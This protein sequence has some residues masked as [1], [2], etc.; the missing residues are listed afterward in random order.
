MKCLL[1]RPLSH[2]GK[3]MFTF[4]KHKIL[5]SVTK[6][7]FNTNRNRRNDSNDEKVEEFY[8]NLEILKLPTHKKPNLKQIKA[9]YRKLALKYHPDLNKDSSELFKK[10]NE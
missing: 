8:K 5:S 3:A 4:I 10:I 7:N 6:S 9:S 2:K 1:Q